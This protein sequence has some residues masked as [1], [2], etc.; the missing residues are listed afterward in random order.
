[1]LIENC[2]NIMLH[3][4]IVDTLV[5]NADSHYFKAQKELFVLALY[6]KNENTIICDNSNTAFLDSVK[7]YSSNDTI[8]DLSKFVM[9]LISK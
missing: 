9:K 3:N 8:P 6:Y 7:T 2:Q 4:Y 1:M 5:K